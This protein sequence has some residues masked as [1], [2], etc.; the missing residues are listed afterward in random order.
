MLELG[1][2]SERVC[3][4]YG[5]DVLELLKI[6]GA[7]SAM[8]VNTANQADSDKLYNAERIVTLDC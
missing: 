2:E 6:A 4:K 3:M 8:S 5:D 1:A 7:M